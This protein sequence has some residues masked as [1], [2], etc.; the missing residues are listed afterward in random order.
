MQSHKKVCA[1]AADAEDVLAVMNSN[2][3]LSFATCSGVSKSLHVAATMTADAV[4][5]ALLGWGASW[6]IGEM[7]IDLT[8][9]I[10]NYLNAFGGTMK[11]VEILRLD[12]S[13]GSFAEMTVPRADFVQLVR[14][15]SSF[16]IEETR[17]VELFRYHMVQLPRFGAGLRTLRMIECMTLHTLVI[18]DTV[19][20]LVLCNVV[21][22]P[23]YDDPDQDRHLV[24]PKGLKRLTVSLERRGFDSIGWIYPVDVD[25]LPDGLEYLYIVP[26]DA[27][28]RSLELFPPSLKSL[29]VF[30]GSSHEPFELMSLPDGLE[31]IELHGTYGEL[32]PPSSLLK[33]TTYGYLEHFMIEPP[34]RLVEVRMEEG[35]NPCFLRELPASIEIVEMDEVCSDE[36]VFVDVGKLPGLKRFSFQCCG[37]CYEPLPLNELRI[38]G[39]SGSDA[40]FSI[41]V[42]TLVHDGIR[43]L[44]DCKGMIRFDADVCDVNEMI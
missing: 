2:G 6:I 7:S 15:T 35:G 25:N 38:R 34:S 26:D 42:T 17:D 39:A 11:P 5:T 14:A 20:D 36:V 40:R 33:V 16:I 21:I 3:R 8:A 30:A 31:Q 44:S 29:T 1:E 27:A 9:D 10:V 43:D 23:D 28:E 22:E 18:P 41:D 4:H 37:N 19:D 32:W 24:L 12:A 13:A